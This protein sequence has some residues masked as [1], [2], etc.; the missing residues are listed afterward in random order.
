VSIWSQ[1]AIFA[2]MKKNHVGL[3]KWR[4]GEILY[5]SGVVTYSDSICVG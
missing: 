2:I 5:V 3:Y 1:L 4:P